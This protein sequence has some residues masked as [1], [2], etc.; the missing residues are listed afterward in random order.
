VDWYRQVVEGCKKV[1]EEY[2]KYAKRP[3]ADPQVLEALRRRA[4]WCR[5]YVAGQ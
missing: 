1:I 2:E 5:R 4:E 3:D